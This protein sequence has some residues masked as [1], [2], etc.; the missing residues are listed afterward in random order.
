M[1]KFAVDRMRSVTVHKMISILIYRSKR[2]LNVFQQPW[3][4]R[5]NTLGRVRVCAY[6]EALS[7][8]ISTT[9]RQGSAG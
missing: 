6:T 3:G 7:T 4:F 1:Q 5:A 2:F 9:L 8:T